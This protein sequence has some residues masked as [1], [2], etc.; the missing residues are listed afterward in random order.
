MSFVVFLSF[1]LLTGS[2][3]KSDDNVSNGT[4]APPPQ[5]VKAGYETLVFNDDFDSLESIDVKGTKKSG[6][7]WYVD[8]PI[9]G[10]GIT[11]PSAYNVSNSVLTV[12]SDGYTANWTLTSYSPGG[13]VGYSFRYGYFE[14]RIRFNPKLGK[15]ARGF[16]AW[17]C[18]SVNHSVNGD[19]SRW[20]ELDFYEAYTGGYADYNGLFVGTVHD[21]ANDSKTHYQNSNNVQWLSDTTFSKWHTYGCLWTPG[22]ITWYFDNDSLM[23]QTYSA[24]KTPYPQT[25]PHAPVGTFSILDTEP[26]GMMLILG[27]DEKWP[28]EVD[29]VRVWRANKTLME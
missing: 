22:R 11:D 15:I 27:S 9:W 1:I 2:C 25:N 10:S 20:A 6:Y 13:K 29:W 23:T 8:A 4:P 21:W 26:L 18:F 3:H 28:M 5:A 12:T 19:P 17:W 16:P 7:K 24:D 14:A